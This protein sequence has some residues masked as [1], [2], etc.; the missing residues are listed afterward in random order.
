M[1][2]AVSSFQKNIN[3]ALLGYS[4]VK[5]AETNVGKDT[6]EGV[7]DNLSRA[8]DIRLAF[9]IFSIIFF[10]M[11]RSSEVGQKIIQLFRGHYEKQ[12]I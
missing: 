4:M 9:I 6:H 1:I 12:N 2:K 5:F 8:I 11:F 7:T 10:Q 3:K